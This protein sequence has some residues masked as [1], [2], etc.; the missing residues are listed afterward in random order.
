MSVRPQGKD[1]PVPVSFQ[2]DDPF[3]L[4]DQLTED[5]RMIRDTARA[6][7][8]DKL[9]PRIVKAYQEEKTDREIFNEMGELGLNGITLPEEYGCANASY[10]AYGLVARE[11]ERVDSG[12]RSM[13]SVQSSLVMYPIY[14]YGDENQRK[15]Y[16]PKLATG[17]WVGCFGLTEPDAGSDPGGMK[18]RAEKVSDGY[19]LTGSKTWIS[20]APIADLFV[21]WAKSSA[22]DNQVRGFVLEKGAKGLSA[23]KIDGKLSLR[24]SATG[25]IVMDGVVVPEE[26][27]L[28]NVSGLKGPFGCLNRA[29]YGI[30]WGVMGA[31]EDCMDRARKYVLERKQFGRPLAAAQL[32]QKKLADMQTDIAL[33]LQGSLRVGRLMD[34]GKMAPEM[35]SIVKRNNCG[36]A[37]DIARMARDMHGANGV[38]I[39]YHV[40]RHAANLETV[41]TYEGTHDVHALVLGRAITGIPAFS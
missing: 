37:L 21:V 35:I 13:N 33:G 7:A 20:N 28:P 41:N 1:K 9:Q 25:E 32:V 36:K 16:L 18:T 11:I 19:R 10:V 24:A 29:R 31:A 4:D 3:R 40:M 39:E 27:L 15:K 2:W 14:A 22:H 23:P 5:E 38:Q 12:Y 30:S 8:Q 6:Y 17:E 34:D 26:N